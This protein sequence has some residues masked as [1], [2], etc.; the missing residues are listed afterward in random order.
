MHDTIKLCACF[1]L[2][3]LQLHI[4]INLLFQTIIELIVN[5]PKVIGTFMV[6]LHFIKYNNVSRSSEVC[7]IAL[8]LHGSTSSGRLSAALLVMTKS[9]FQG[10]WILFLEQMLYGILAVIQVYGPAALVEMV[11]EEVETIV[12]HLHYR[13][14]EDKGNAF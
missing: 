8:V 1:W 7:N 10:S 11:N 12:V 5:V 2:S 14:D 4:I 6:A 3:V 13:L 9:M